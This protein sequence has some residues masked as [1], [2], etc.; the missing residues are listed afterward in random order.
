M[1]PE[2]QFISQYEGASSF[3]QSLRQQWEAR[4]SL[5]ER[6]IECITR[7]LSKA[8]PTAIDVT[9]LQ[10]GGGIE[11]RRW[12]ARKIAEEFKTIPAHLEA[13]VAFRNLEITEIH[14]ETAKAVQ[15]TF[16]YSSKICERCHVCGAELDTDV[17]RACGIGPVCAKKLGFKRASLGDAGAIVERME[18]ICREVGEVG[19]R[20][21]PK[22][23]IVRQW[24]QS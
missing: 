7:E 6:Q 14:R 18:A 22:S 11:I 4:G 5:T 13:P 2:I 12:L 9:G 20:W 10:T 1:T 3:F 8:E 21:I 16:R 15:V 24:G 19:P 23:Q 17:S